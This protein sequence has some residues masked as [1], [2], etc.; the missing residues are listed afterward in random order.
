MGTKK[1]LARQDKTKNYCFTS[2]GPF[3]LTP[4]GGP[5]FSGTVIITKLFD[6][7]NL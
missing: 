4:I 6:Y 5:A 2:A 1:A 7:V 3:G